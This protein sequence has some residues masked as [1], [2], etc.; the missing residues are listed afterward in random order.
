MAVFA[1]SD[2]HLP[3]GEPESKS[4]AVFGARWHDY[5][6]RFEKNWRSVVSKNDTVIIPGD[7]SWAMRLADAKDDL[8]FLDSLPG[9]KIIGKGNHDFWWVGLSKM[10]SFLSENGIFSIDFL[11]N[12]AYKVEDLIICGTRGWFFDESDQADIFDTSHEKLILR[13]ASRLELSLNEGLKLSGG[14]VSP[15]RVFLHFP[16]VFGE[17]QCTPIVDTLL[18]FA[19]T[20]VYYG[21][22]HTATPFPELSVHRGVR[23]HS[24]SSDAVGFMPKLVR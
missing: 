8:L 1:I 13:E 17:K 6:S 5:I 21:H 9:K 10:R 2:P 20:D 18:Y 19:V 16:A 4:M 22:V 3:G 12:N 23:F 24:V 7:I 15:I 14:D 11:Q